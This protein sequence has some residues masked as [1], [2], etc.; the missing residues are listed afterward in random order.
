MDRSLQIL[1][2]SYTKFLETIGT[3]SIESYFDIENYSIQCVRHADWKFILTIQTNLAQNVYVLNQTKLS[4]DIIQYIYAYLENTIQVVSEFTFS[5]DYPFKPHK[6][7]AISG[8]KNIYNNQFNKVCKHSIL[9]KLALPVAFYNKQL[10]DS[11][12]T[13]S[14][15]ENHI[16]C[17]ITHILSIV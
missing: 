8:Y 11:W 3:R 13:C 10:V 16:L 5:T 2:R 14:L 1:N 9:S 17:Y 6:C 7:V 12:M 4:P 15:F